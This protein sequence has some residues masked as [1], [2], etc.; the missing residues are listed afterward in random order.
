MQCRGDLVRAQRF[1]AGLWDNALSG[2]VRD[3]G[4]RVRTAW[5]ILSG[6]IPE[7]SDKCLEGRV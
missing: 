3:T 2:L 1:V 5:N 4:L 7:P 6:F